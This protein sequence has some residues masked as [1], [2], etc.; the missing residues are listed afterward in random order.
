MLMTVMDRLEED[1]AVVM[2]SLLGLILAAEI[3]PMDACIQ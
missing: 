3:R 1:L 2:N